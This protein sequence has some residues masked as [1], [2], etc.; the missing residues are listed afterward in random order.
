MTNE[1]HIY[2]ETENDE[3]HRLLGGLRQVEAP[4]DFD[5]HVKARIAKG[6]P[7]EARRPWAWSP[8]SLAIP[9][10]LLLTFGTFVGYRVLNEAPGANVVAEVPVAE[11]PVSQNAF[12]PQAETPPPSSDSLAVSQ[13]DVA[14]AQTPEKLNVKPIVKTAPTSKPEKPGGGSYDTAA[15]TGAN[16]IS[17]KDEDDLAP[18]PQGRRILISTREFLTNSGIAASYAGAGGRIT[19]VGGAAAAA[20]IVAGDVIES[21][22]VQ[23]GIIRVNRDGKSMTFRIK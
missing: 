11:T 2:Q 22:N 17:K 10:L 6:R 3:I 13:P 20:G 5:F 18:E 16:I 23:S 4:K 15:G 8:V 9:L 12:A 19:S 14:S 21:V 7:A 1:K